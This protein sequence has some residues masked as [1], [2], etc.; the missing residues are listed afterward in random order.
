MSEP[1]TKSIV[2]PADPEN[3]F[4]MWVEDIDTWWPKSHSR[5][6]DPA[7]RIVIESFPGGRFYEHA[8]DGS[9]SDFGTILTHDPPRRLVYQWFLGADVDRPTVVDIAFEPAPG[10]TRVTVE[11]RAAETSAETWNRTKGGYDR[12]WSDVLPC[13]E[14]AITERS[15]T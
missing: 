11:H 3:A 13:Y 4:R 7:T 6:K 14:N 15:Q 8:T 10:G 9:E 2:V 1:I 5:S 12:A